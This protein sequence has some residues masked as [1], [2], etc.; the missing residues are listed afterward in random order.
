MD[1]RQ[2]GRCNPAISTAVAATPTTSAD[3][4]TDRLVLALANEAVAVLRAG[5]V[6]DADT[7]DA[8]MIFGSGYA[9]F[10][11]GPLHYARS[12]GF[13]RCR[14]RLRELE[15]RYGARFAPDPGWDALV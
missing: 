14:D 6:S 4:L 13:G 15:A 9:P 12:A 1:G 3:D 5:I 2:A 10:R 7:L 8:A 11:G